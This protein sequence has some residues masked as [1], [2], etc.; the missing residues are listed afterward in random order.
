[1]S[2][3]DGI[4]EVVAIADAGTFA[5]G[6]K[7]LGL[8]P[9]QMTRIIAKIEERLGTQFFVR[10]T[11]RL[12]LTDTGRAFVEQCRNILQERDELLAQ[13]NSSGEP[14]GTLRITCSIAL[15]E[16]FVAPLVAQFTMAYPKMSVT[17]DLTNR[18]VDIVGDGY[19]V[20][21]RTGHVADGR[22]V[23]RRIASRP[24]DTCA[25]PDY[26][27]I[28]GEP[29]AIEEL[30]R[31][32]CLIGTNLNWHFLE[33]GQ[34]RIFKPDGRFRC[35]SGTAVVNAAIAGMGICQLPKFYVQRAVEQGVLTPI[36]QRFRAE[37][38]AIWIVYPQRRHLQPKV[39][40]LVALLSR[41]LQAA[42][43]LGLGATSERFISS[44]VGSA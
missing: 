38:E 44:G 21:I 25:S 32:A 36:L 6:A 2:D 1:M 24:I 39:R 9:S 19:D 12:S 23:A 43:D 28:A 42:L 8:S 5:G 37:P 13:V 35:N 11:R 7:L 40:S 16:R 20:G 14:Q 15:G 27:R 29:G 22:V 18:V 41:E 10:T 30:D 33:V 4:E 17:L 3:W 31:H 26:L 34:P